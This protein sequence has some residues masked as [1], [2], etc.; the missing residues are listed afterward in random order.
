MFIRLLTHFQHCFFNAMGKSTK[1][2]YPQQFR[3]EK[4]G[5]S[6]SIRDLFHQ[7][8]PE[9]RSQEQVRMAAGQSDPV[10]EGRD[11]SN[12]SLGERRRSGERDLNLPLTLATMTSITADI[13]PT[14]TTA[15]SEEAR[16]L[17]SRLDDVV[18]AGDCRYQAVDRLEKMSDHFYSSSYNSK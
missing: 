9:T 13:K 18:K 10:A 15:I 2:T 3:K 7:Q 4:S 16:G 6:R 1:G 12:L 17:S 14:L 11:D 8:A 5:P